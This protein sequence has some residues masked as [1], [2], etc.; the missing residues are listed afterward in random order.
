MT[1]E[2]LI[3]RIDD[4]EWKDRNGYWQINLESGHDD[5]NKDK[6]EI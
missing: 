3:K 6:S 1:K 5:E 2:E 4:L